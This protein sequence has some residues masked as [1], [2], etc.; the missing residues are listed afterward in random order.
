[1]ATV[2]LLV[3]TSTKHTLAIVHIRF[4]HGREIDLQVPTEFVMFPEYWNNKSQTFSKRIQYSER[5]TPIEKTN[6]EK[7][8][9]DIKNYVLNEINTGELLT[10]EI[11]SKVVYQFHHPGVVMEA[12]T[13]NKYIQHFINDC[14]SGARLTYKMTRYRTSTL[15]NFLGFKSQFDTFQKAQKRKYDFKDIDLQFYNDYIQFFNAK[16]YTPNTIGRHTKYLKLIMRSARD[17]NLHNNIET[18][19]SYFKVLSEEVDKIYLTEKELEAMYNLDLENSPLLNQARDVFLIGCY[20]A[21]R[22][23]NYSKISKENIRFVDG[24]PRII[25][26]IQKKT[27]TKVIIPIKTN[28]AILL[29][30]YDFK[31]PKIYYQKLNDRIKIVGKLAGID[32][33][34]I[35]E[36]TRGGRRVVRKNPKYDL[37]QT[38]TARRSG[39][40]NMYLAG[41]PNIDTMKI[42]GHKTEKEFLKYIKVTK[43]ETAQN[44]A[45]HSWFN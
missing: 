4:R 41:I 5:F 19:K 39:C 43:E 8:F 37:I 7:R 21:Q 17:E 13:L 34:I 1:M 18:E 25:E 20:T 33:I 6:L 42:S 28:L 29:K 26:L 38:H 31:I 15:K 27:D 24:E 22:F 35:I 40:T 12:P 10:K 11:L 3:R 36:Q 30:K 32:D 23:D 16:D 9:R 45:K 14:T 2:K 44:L